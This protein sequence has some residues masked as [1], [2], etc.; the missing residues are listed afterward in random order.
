TSQSDRERLAR[1]VKIPDAQQRWEQLQDVL[2]VNRYVSH[3]ACELFTSHTDGYAMNRNNYRI[4]C[5]PDTGRFTFIGHGVDWAFG[6]PGVSMQPPQ[7][8]LVT[9]AVLT[10]PEGAKLFKERRLTLFTNIFQLEVL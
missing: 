8:S 3:L 7:S 9:K 4:Y 6:N 2:D 10:T 5:N 1:V